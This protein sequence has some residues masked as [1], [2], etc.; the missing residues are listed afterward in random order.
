MQISPLG[1]RLVSALS[2]PIGEW[3]KST[4][5]FNPNHNHVYA[6]Q[7]KQASRPLHVHTTKQTPSKK[8]CMYNVLVSLPICELKI[9]KK[10]GIGHQYLKK[11]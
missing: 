8:Y 1:C 7:N 10:S 2:I 3:H 9:N 6:D 4:A 5:D 11:D